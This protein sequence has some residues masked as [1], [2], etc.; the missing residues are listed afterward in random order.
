MYRSTVENNCNVQISSHLLHKPTLGLPYVSFYPG[1]RFVPA[2]QLG[3]Q[4]ASIALHE[5]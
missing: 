5:H 1:Q 2:S 3:I 4:L